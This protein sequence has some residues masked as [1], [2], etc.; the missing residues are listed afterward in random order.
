MLPIRGQGDDALTTTQANYLAPT[1]IDVVGDQPAQN[2]AADNSGA[3]QALKRCSP[4]KSGRPDHHGHQR[5]SEC[6][7]LT[8]ARGEL[9]R[10]NAAVAAASDP[11]RLAGCLQLK[12]VSRARA[13]GYKN[14]NREPAA[15]QRGDPELVGEDRQ[16]ATLGPLGPG[17]LDRGGDMKCYL[18]RS[19]NLM[20]T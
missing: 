17:L 14:S 18:P 11:T 13:N 6:V 20:P 3:V 1:G 10:A 4:R 16:F 8:G 15:P 5:R 2:A 7:Y 12:S 9:R 19:P